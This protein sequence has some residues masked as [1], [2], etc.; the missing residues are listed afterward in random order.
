MEL[1]GV[2]LNVI[3]AYAPQVECIR[4]EKETFWLDLNETVEKIPRNERIVVEADLNGNVEEV[5]NG[6]E[7]CMA[8]HGLGKRNN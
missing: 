3:S 2:M 4:E 6:D 7:E 1:D 8:R 5:N